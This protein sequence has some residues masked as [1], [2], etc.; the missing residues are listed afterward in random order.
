[1]VQS[2]GDKCIMEA[3]TPFILLLVSL[4]AQV[5]SQRF[6]ALLQIIYSNSSNN[7]ILY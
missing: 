4:W 1:M 5:R 7:L 6:L 3:E 2:K